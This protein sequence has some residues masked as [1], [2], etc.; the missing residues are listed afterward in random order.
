V[1]PGIRSR[2]T[3]IIF[4]WNGEKL[5]HAIRGDTGMLMLYPGRVGKFYLPCRQLPLPAPGLPLFE[6][7]LMAAG[8]YFIWQPLSSLKK[9]PERGIS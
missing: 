7:L 3:I 9:Q 8:L 2:K 6:R 1:L 4:T 5:I